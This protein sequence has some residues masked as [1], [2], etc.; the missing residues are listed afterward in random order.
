M[1]TVCINWSNRSIDHDH[2]YR[3]CRWFKQQGGP[4]FEAWSVGIEHDMGQNPCKVMIPPPQRATMSHSPAP[5]REIDIQPNCSSQWS[6]WIECLRGGFSLSL[7]IT[8]PAWLGSYVSF[9]LTESATP[10]Q[11]WNNASRMLLWGI[12][13]LP[14][15][16]VHCSAAPSQFF[17]S[18]SIAHCPQVGNPWLSPQGSQ[19]HK[20]LSTKNCVSGHGQNSRTQSFRRIYIFTSSKL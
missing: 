14:S 1:E 19:R 7:S 10:N 20:Q 12:Q 17:Q 6:Q 18:T 8:I 3:N 4:W 13:P 15:R 5:K 16:H 9:K 11:S 2:L